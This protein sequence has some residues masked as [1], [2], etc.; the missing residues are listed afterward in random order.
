MFNLKAYDRKVRAVPTHRNSMSHP[1]ITLE[2]EE[3][4]VTIEA[5]NVNSRPCFEI[6]VKAKNQPSMLI[7]GGHIDK[8]MQEI[9]ERAYGN[10]V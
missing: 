8:I 6:R 7:A 4:E 10:T 2:S 5:V 9:L 1:K 3:G